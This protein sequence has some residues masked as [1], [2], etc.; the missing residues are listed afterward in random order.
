MSNGLGASRLVSNIPDDNETTLPLRLWLQL[1]KCTKAIE[2][3]MAGRFRR[4]HNQ[5]LSR[6][7]LLSQ[8][9]RIE[10]EW[11][12]IGEV[13]AM[14]MAVVGMVDWIHYHP[15]HL[16]SSTQPTSATRFS[17]YD[18]T[19]IWIAN[20]SDSSLTGNRDLPDLTRRQ[21]QLHA[22]PIA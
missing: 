15:P 5:S 12:P 6:F 13:A 18:S 8:L 4:H 17:E 11:A 10:E 9:H 20:L 7:D 16:W 2:S 14:V 3:E 21:P 22:I 19:V 1:M